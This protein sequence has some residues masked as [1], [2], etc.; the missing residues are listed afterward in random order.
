MIPHRRHAAILAESSTLLAGDVTIGDVI[1]ARRPGATDRTHE[2]V[3]GAQHIG[4]GHIRL[5]LASGFTLEPSTDVPVGIVSVTDG[6]WRQHDPG[7]EHGAGHDR[8]CLC[9][10]RR[11]CGCYLWDQDC[12]EWSPIPEPAPPADIDPIPFAETCCGKCPGATCYVDQM[13][14]A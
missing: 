1:L 2:T 4:H 3:I 14:G 12:P 10:Q 5:R 13:T 7:D 9:W 11:H 8:S 6:P